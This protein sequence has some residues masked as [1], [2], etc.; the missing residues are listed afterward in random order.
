MASLPV[1]WPTI[2]TTSFSSTVANW[3]LTPEETFNPAARHSTSGKS[4]FAS[5]EEIG[6]RNRSAPFP[7]TTTAGRTLRLVRSVNGIGRR[8]T[9]F[10]EQFIEDVVGVI[11][12]G[13]HQGFL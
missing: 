2:L 8:T 1:S 11:V 13:F 4:V 10:L 5:T 3:A 6:T 9:S 12:P 7:P